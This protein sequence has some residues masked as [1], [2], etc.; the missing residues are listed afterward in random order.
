MFSFKG[1]LLIFLDHI[2]NKKTMLLITQNV[3]FTAYNQR[4][5]LEENVPFKSHIWLPLLTISMETSWSELKGSG[6]VSR[7]QQRHIFKY[8]SKVTIL[9]VTI[10]KKCFYS[11]ASIVLKFAD[12]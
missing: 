12:F 3:I 10:N 7:S 5:H 9:S 1:T 6:D 4:M 11:I 8:P 2:V